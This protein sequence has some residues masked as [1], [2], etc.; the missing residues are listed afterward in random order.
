MQRDQSIFVPGF[1]RK[2][3]GFD[4]FWLIQA[5]IKSPMQ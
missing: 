3:L 4:D 2:N 5:K 1:S